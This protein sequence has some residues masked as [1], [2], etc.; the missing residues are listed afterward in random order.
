MKRYCAKSDR[1][2]HSDSGQSVETSTMSLK[3]F[4]DQVPETAPA[5][6]EDFETSKET[7]AKSERQNP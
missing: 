6:D 1:T 7:Q 5:E 3:D 4:S 2:S